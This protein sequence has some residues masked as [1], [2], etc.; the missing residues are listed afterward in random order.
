MRST[1]ARLIYTRYRSI[2]FHDDGSVHL[3]RL[4]GSSITGQRRGGSAIARER[5]IVLIATSCR[6]GGIG[7]PQIDCVYASP[8]TTSTTSATHTGGYVPARGVPLGENK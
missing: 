7:F 5:A 2:G 4:E 1:I 3:A 6:R 8:A